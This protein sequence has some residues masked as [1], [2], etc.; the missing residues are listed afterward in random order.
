VGTPGQWQRYGRSKK[1]DVGPHGG[2]SSPSSL[3]VESNWQFPGD[4]DVQVDFQMG[5]GWGAPASQ[6]LDGATLGA[7]IDGQMYHL[8]RLRSSSEDILLPWSSAAWMN[9]GKP[10]T[11]TSGK[12]RLI[13]TGTQLF[14][15]DDVGS[16]WQELA[17]VKV[18]LSPANIYMA[19]GSVFVTHGF[20]TYFD[21]FHINAGLTTFA[22]GFETP[23][24][25]L[26]Q[27]PPDDDF[28]GPS[29]D[30]A[31][32]TQQINGVGRSVKMGS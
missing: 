32:W 10:E 22:Q 28:T 1:W 29:L 19:N 3:T 21:N 17:E 5:N 23:V 2:N 4:F 7:R 18:P 15:L 26:D 30:P 11:A 24:P 16:G 31:K 6:H 8:T 20:T 12:Y 25:V 13:R 9:N 14:L 27:V